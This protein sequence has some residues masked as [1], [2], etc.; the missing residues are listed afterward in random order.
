MV[1]LPENGHIIY[2]KWIDIL[3]NVLIHG[4]ISMGISTDNGE[5]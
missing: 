3:V 2:I 1:L 5:Q 4:F